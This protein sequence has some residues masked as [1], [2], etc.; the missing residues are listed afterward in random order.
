[1]GPLHLE[2]SDPTATEMA[3]LIQIL[4]SLSQVQS[5]SL[6]S[7][8][9]IARRIYGRPRPWPRIQEAYQLLAALKDLP[10][11]H[12]VTLHSFL[13]GRPGVAMLN[14]FSP[15]LQYL[16]L[17]GSQLGHL[18]WRSLIKGLPSHKPGMVPMTLVLR[19]SDLTPQD[20]VYLAARMIGV[21]PRR[22]RELQKKNRIHFPQYPHLNIGKLVYETLPGQNNWP[23]DQIATF[24]PI[25]T[26]NT[27]LSVLRLG[28]GRG[29]RASSLK[30][31]TT[32]RALTLVG[33]PVTFRHNGP[34][35]YC[36]AK[37]KLKDQRY[38]S[39][40]LGDWLAHSTHITHLTYES[41]KEV[42]SPQIS[43]GLSQNTSLT[44]LSLRNIHLD[45]EAWV[46]LG[47]LQSLD[48]NCVGED[49]LNYIID[50]I[51]MNGPL[52]EL[53]CV[54]WVIL[55]P[56]D[57]YPRLWHALAVNSNLRRLEMLTSSLLVHTIP[58]DIV[59]LNSSLERLQ[60]HNMIP[61]PAFLD[62]NRHNRA[63]RKLTLYQ[64]LLNTCV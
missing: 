28:D 57:V 41:Q 34:T 23:H 60:F 46:I 20:L 32:L 12:A 55:P 9:M 36:L 42:G 27:I 53:R 30:I 49:L 19:G 4:P 10:H 64:I 44:Q 59:G 7:R 50:L 13:P 25:L 15:N 16:D 47:R 18:G 33:G 21:T 43:A 45:P 6:I 8:I 11:L 61:I 38:A 17:T 58:L 39:P 51:S 35:H 40:G 63:Q 48:L 37:L 1:M 62:R 14:S 2:I 54:S 26:Y 24:N 56:A 22:F 5:V 3:H 29:A 31:N 52:Q